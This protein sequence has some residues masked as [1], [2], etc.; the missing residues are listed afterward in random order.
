LLQ[1]GVPE[2][3]ILVA[4]PVAVGVPVV[5]L[6]D[7]LHLHKVLKYGSLLVR[8]RQAQLAMGQMG[9]TLF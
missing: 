7:S 3:E 6:Q 8:V 2:E 5:L 9:V 1:V 4:A